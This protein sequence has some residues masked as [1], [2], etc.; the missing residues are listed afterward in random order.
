MNTT[1]YKDLP[2]DLVEALERCIELCGPEQLNLYY[3]L[4]DPATG[5]FYY[6]ISSRDTEEMTPFAEGTRFSIEALRYGGIELPDWE[7]ER[8]GN[9]ILNHQDV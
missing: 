1:D 4:F 3:E 5:G 8:V 7:K 2:K 9:W 6:S